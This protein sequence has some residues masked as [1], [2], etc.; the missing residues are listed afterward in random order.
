MVER[1]R[2]RA[3]EVKKL[4]HESVGLTKPTSSGPPSRLEI[5]VRGDV[6]VLSPKFSGQGRQAG[7]SR[8]FVAIL[9]LNFFFGK[10]QAL[11]LQLVCVES[12]HLTQG[13]LLFSRSAD[14]S[15]NAI[16]KQVP[17]QRYLDSSLTQQLGTTAQPN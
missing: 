8:F 12:A 16:F 17:S 11:G 7:Y 13:S 10:P 2:E 15:V 5:R 3:M 9:R 6:A 14:C 1:G 4:A